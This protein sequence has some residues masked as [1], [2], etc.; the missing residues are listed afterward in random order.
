MNVKI[1]TFIMIA[2]ISWVLLLFSLAMIALIALG[3]VSDSSFAIWTN[4]ITFIIGIW[5]PQP[6]NKETSPILPTTTID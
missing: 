1:W 4:M 2:A 5:I 6:K 3:L